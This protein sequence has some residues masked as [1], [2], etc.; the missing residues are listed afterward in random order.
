MKLQLWLCV[1]ALLVLTGCGG[2]VSVTSGES[3]EDTA[4]AKQKT[5][6]LRKQREREQAA[7]DADEKWLQAD[8]KR[9]H[10]NIK[11]FKSDPA[12]FVW[13]G[14]AKFT[15]PHT[16]RHNSSVSSVAFS[17]DGRQ[18]LIGSLDNT[19]VLRTIGSGEILQSWQHGGS[20]NSV[21]FSPDGL[22]V[23][24]GSADNTAVLRAV[25]SGE[26]LQSWRRGGSVNSVAFSPDGR[27][28]LI[29]S[30]DNTAV[31][32]AIG[33]G[34]VLQSWKHRG[35][36]NSVAFSPDGLQVLTG[37]ADN[38]AV[39]RAV[40]SGKTLQTWRHQS[41]VYSVAFSPDGRQ[42]IT[43]SRDSTAVLR[44]IRRN[45]I[46]YT[47]QHKDTVRSVAFS[48][49]G[50]QVL[51]GSVDGTAVLR[52]VRRRN[53]LHTWQHKGWV[54]SV[55]FSPDGRQVLTGSRD[56]TVVLRSNPAAR[57]SLEQAE[58]QLQRWGKIWIVKAV[59]RHR[60]LSTE[61]ASRQTALRSP[62]STKP[63]KGLFES[64]TKFKARVAQAQADCERAVDDYNATVAAFNVDVQYHYEYLEQMVPLAG[65]ARVMRDA[66][67]T[68]YGIPTLSDA[69][70]DADAE[71]WYLQLDASLIKNFQRTLVLPMSRAEARTRQTAVRAAIASVTM[72]VTEQNDLLWEQARIHL[73]DTGPGL[74]ARFIDDGYTPATLRSTVAVAGAA[75]LTVPA[76]PYK[77]PAQCTYRQ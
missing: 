67:V 70:Y 58:Q 15:L 34:E 24:I 42:V 53:P 55:A 21:A 5:K 31:L 35:N 75:P 14:T 64:T 36:V 74:L 30:A 45:K 52:D 48:P 73:T 54:Y 39:L 10:Q 41:S 1:G 47:W 11:I 23:L 46:L 27:Q 18:V 37:S 57:V 62:V 56:N 76:E 8:L 77:D 68:A 69:R 61:L 25:G 19:A 50:R 17:P 60:Q 38:T 44:D 63:I 59:K 3:A 4:I 12:R 71:E 6:A 49:N 51:T 72:R 40:G 26:V 13:S 22:Q 16:W 65:R 33:S 43:G 2:S 28:V 7:Q 20:V 9:L 29:G 66:F 32:R